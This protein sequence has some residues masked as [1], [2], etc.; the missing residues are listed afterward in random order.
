M[1]IFS[2]LLGVIYAAE[3]PNIVFVLADDLGIS[4]IAAFA[5][6]FT[7]KPINDL[8]YETPNIDRLVGKGIAFSQ[9]YANQL[10]SPTRAAIMTG[11]YA[12]RHGF[13]TTTPLTKT[14]YNQGLPLTPSSAIRVGD[15]K[16]IWDWHGKLERFNIPADPY[17]ENDLSG[18][19]PEKRDEL[20]CTLK[21]WLK[22][23]AEPHY[24]PHRNA[25]YN[26][27]D[28][29]RPYPFIDLSGDLTQ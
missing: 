10:C 18:R 8:F 5:S 26:A 29:A 2:P 12:V 28:D 3:R 20:M 19:M 9:A 17:E 22:K 27:G 24:M 25:I 4:D 16:L 21:E 15:Y 6:H 14:H 11:Q 7:G 1:V 13:T 23:N